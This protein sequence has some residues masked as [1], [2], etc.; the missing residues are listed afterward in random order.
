MKITVFWDVSPCNLVE[1]YRCFRG[2]HFLHHQDDR[3]D[4]G[5]A[6]RLHGATPQKTVIFNILFVFHYGD[7]FLVP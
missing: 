4:D 7:L 2:A 5:A 1:V 3:A 6:T